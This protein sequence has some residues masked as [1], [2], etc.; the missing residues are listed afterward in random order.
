MNT[1]ENTMTGKYNRTPFRQVRIAR[2]LEII[3]EFGHVL[4]ACDHDNNP[5][6]INEGNAAFIADAL[7]ERASIV[8]LCLPAAIAEIEKLQHRI[9]KLSDLLN[10]FSDEPHKACEILGNYLEGKEV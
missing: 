7:N 4:C 8:A 9:A 6:A 2:S 3:N 10:E 5:K 1:N